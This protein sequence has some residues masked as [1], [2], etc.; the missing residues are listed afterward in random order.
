MQWPSFLRRKDPPAGPPGAVDDASSVQRVRTRARRRLV[1]AV[2]LLGIGVI[3]FPLLFESQPRPIPIDI[4]I[5]IP[6]KDN[7]PPLTSPAARAPVRDSRADGEVAPRAATPGQLSAPA[8][9]AGPASTPAA[10]VA[11][12]PTPPPPVARVELP[13]AAASAATG[14]RYVLQVGAYTDATSVR[15]VRAKIE[16]LGLKTY[17][18]TVDTSDGKRTRVRIGPFDSRA[19]AATAGAKLKAAGLPFNLLEL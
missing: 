18:Q 3:G 2:V 8:A 9:A 14:E 13:P 10:E 5:E 12:A 4:P 11:V 15:E 16:R 17:I 19:V 7:V 6:R 1:G